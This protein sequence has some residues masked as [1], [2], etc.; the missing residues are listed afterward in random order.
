[1]IH[2]IMQHIFLLWNTMWSSVHNGKI[3]FVLDKKLL[4]A[5][6]K[7]ARSVGNRSALI[8]E[9]ITEHL[10]SLQIR[11]WEEQ[12]RSAHSKHPQTIEESERWVI[13]AWPD[14]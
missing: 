4:Q 8:F 13:E 5:T 7:A 14:E 1:M 3:Q 6:V 11:A 9:A 2:E 12:E 10:R